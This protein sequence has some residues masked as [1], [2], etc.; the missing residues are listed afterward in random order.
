MIFVLGERFDA[1]LFA[2]F[3]QKYDP[4]SL[5]RDG[6][7]LV[8]TSSK[9]PPVDERYFDLFES[10]VEGDGDIQLASRKFQAQTAE[11]GFG[12]VKIG[13]A[14]QNTVLMAGPCSVE[15][16]EQLRT[17]CQSLKAMGV[18]CLRGGAFKPRTTPYGF[19]GLGAEGL[20]LLADARAEYGL[21]IVSEVRDSTHVEQVIEVVDVVQVGAKAMYDHGILR[22]CGKGGKPVLLKRGFGTTLQEFVQAAEF[23]LSSGNPQVML[24]E[25]GIRTFETKTR[26][27]L[28]LCGVEYLKRHV[29]LPII[30]DP[31]HAMGHR[32][33]VPGLSLAATAL[34]VDGLLIEAHPEPDSALSDA[35][36]QID[37][38]T[39]GRLKSQVTQVAQA[40]GRYVV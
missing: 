37:L 31:S 8:V 39:L 38:D 22:A 16:K 4:L 29:N 14:T 36:Q 12:S 27:T 35:A 9:G 25:R 11:V 18:Q 5:K 1:N 32:Y 30:V 24:C 7:E 3:K 2:E 20:R 33:G 13:G 6:R 17:V 34:G 15:S 23:I 21:S 10:R 26:F 28:D 40:V 19:Q